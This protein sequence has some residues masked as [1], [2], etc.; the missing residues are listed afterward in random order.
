MSSPAVTLA[1]VKDVLQSSDLLTEERGWEDVAVRGVAQDSRT[2]REGDVFLAWQGTELDAHDFVSDAV[3]RGAVAAVV[4]R[5]VEAAIPQLVVRDGRVAAALVADRVL[6]SPSRELLTMGVT[7]TNGKTTTA[8]L[9]R[10]LL[11]PEIPTAVIGT[12]GLLEADGGVRPGTEGLTTPGPVQ[13]A[14]WLRDL[15]DGGTEAVVIE[16][17]SHALE[18]ARLEGVRFDLAVF[19]NLTQDHL[20]YHGDMAGYLQAKAHLVDLVVGDGT[21]VLNADEPAWDVLERGSRRA[22]TFGIDSAA[23]LRATNL[24]LGGT[25]TSFTL[26]AEGREW[27]VHLPLVG[28]YN[29]ENALAAAAT[30]KGAGVGMERITERLG[31]TPPVSGRLEPVVSGPFSVLIDFA[32]TPAAL[33][34]ALQAVRPLTKGRVIVVF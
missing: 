6:G 24:R 16:A 9:V 11:S 10:H 8:S 29:V 33:E 14:L 26:L 7:G 21:L 13:L 25:G 34:G 23:D 12:L 15:A 27:S 4:E 28:R 18:Q 2:V 32:H 5:P 17:S 31:T 1:A 3:T 30:A 22:I 19:T 20:D